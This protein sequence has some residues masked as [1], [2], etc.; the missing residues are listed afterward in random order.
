MPKL[1]DVGR[2]DQELG[3]NELE[4]HWLSVDGL[5]GVGL[6]GDGLDLTCWISLAEVEVCRQRLRAV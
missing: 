4:V 5:D 2:V 3:G 6:D 1:V